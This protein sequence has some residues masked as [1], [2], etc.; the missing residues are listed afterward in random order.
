MLRIVQHLRRAVWS[1]LGHNA[2]T[3]AKAAAYSAILSLFPA[4]LVVTTLF[5][6][7]PSGDSVGGVLRAAL[8]QFLPPDTMSLVQSYFV[9]YHA[10]SLRIVWGSVFVSIFAAMG[11]LL[12]LME[13]FRRAYRLP[14]GS[15][16]FWRERI[17]ALLLVPGTM[18]PMAAATLFLA[19][20]HSIEHWMIENSEHELHFYVIIL[21]RLIRWVIALQASIFSLALI[22][23]YGVPRHHLPT[24]SGKF[25][26]VR[27]RWRETLP[28]A[29]IATLTWFV[30]TL[31]YGW[32][33]TRF[34]TYS[35]V[36]GSLAAG[37]AT[38]IW[39][40]MVAL[41]VL[42]GAE[43]NAQLFPL[44]DA[45]RPPASV[46]PREFSDEFPGSED[47]RPR[48]AAME[49]PGAR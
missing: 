40:Y 24:R 14:R 39:L 7:T 19:F 13:G 11:V 9:S 32:Y 30:I 1:A 47:S 21:W 2:I 8:R 17:V 20:G 26:W 22:Y 37:I 45:V 33:V 48:S 6:V 27:T 23:H 36:Y 35:I 29:T 25:N 16:G 4:M 38:L 41:S 34:A 18:V 31:V 49:M 5:A 12:S 46:N 43:F 10:R 42:I 15:W 44:P 3:M 28:G